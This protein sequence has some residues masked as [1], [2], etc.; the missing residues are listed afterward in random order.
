MKLLEAVYDAVEFLGPEFAASWFY[1]GQ[2]ALL[3]RPPLSPNW[4]RV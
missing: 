4:L 1:H 2:M 3:K